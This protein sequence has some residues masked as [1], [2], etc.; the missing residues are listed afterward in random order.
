M[1][2]F[3]FDDFLPFGKSAT[4]SEKAAAPKMENWQREHVHAIHELLDTPPEVYGEMS[5]AF[6]HIIPSYNAA[7]E[8]HGRNRRV[9]PGI[10]ARL[11]AARKQYYA[12]R[13]PSATAEQK[14]A[15]P[16]LLENYRD[17]RAAV[18]NRYKE[19]VLRFEKENPSDTHAQRYSTN[20]GIQSMGPWWHA[21]DA[22]EGRVAILRDSSKLSSRK[23]ELV[24]R[25]AALR[26]FLSPLYATLGMAAWF[27][28]LAWGKMASDAEVAARYEQTETN[29]REQGYADRKEEQE[30][31]QVVH[32]P[33]SEVLVTP[34]SFVTSGAEMETAPRRTSAPPAA[35][36]ES[37]IEPIAAESFTPLPPI[38]FEDLPTLD[39]LPKSED[40][41]QIH[42]DGP[43]ENSNHGG[44]L[45][46]DEHIR[47]LLES[48][49]YDKILREYRRDRRR[50]H[51]PNLRDI[52]GEDEV[53]RPQPESGSGS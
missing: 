11:S 35:P 4:A 34:D 36:R 12:A 10:M 43:Q 19:L 20:V 49:S 14:A 52:Y 31:P 32:T 39:P 6:E 9:G 23:L 42:S 48:D 3:R 18:W 2:F 16:E 40:L 25:F 8:P 29:Q 37:R 45:I 53:E 5:E 1:G 51:I 15:L 28:F 22:V 46:T 27:G 24:G 44:E 17:G 38:S 13:L 47:E 30:M 50:L 21:D 7:L 41:S 33:L 26:P